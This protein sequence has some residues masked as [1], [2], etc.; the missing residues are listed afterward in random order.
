M[1][2]MN[3][4][5]YQQPLWAFRLAGAMSLFNLALILII[6]ATAVSTDWSDLASSAAANEQE[7]AAGRIMKMIA[8]MVSSQLFES[9]ANWM[10][11]VIPAD[12]VSISEDEG[13]AL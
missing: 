3:V 8:V 12:C 5:T 13:G 4:V 2:P 1:K 6:V 9:A 10:R 11:R 7:L